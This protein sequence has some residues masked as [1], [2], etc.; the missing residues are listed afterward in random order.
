MHGILASVALFVLLVFQ[1]RQ[2]GADQGPVPPALTQRAWTEGTVRIIVELDTSNHTPEGRLSSAAAIVQRQDIATRQAYVRHG[3]RGIRHRIIHQYRTIPYLALEAG[4]DALRIIDA[5]KGIVTR[6]EEDALDAPTLAESGPLV[7]APTAQS[8][9]WDG[10]GMVIAT[11]DTGVD[12]DHPFL[13]GRVVDEAC[14]SS[15]GNCPNGLTVQTGIGAGVP[16]TYAAE[17]CKHGTHVAGI[18]AGA[19]VSF[20]GIAPGAE[21]LPIQVFSEFTGAFCAGTEDPCAAAYVSDQVAA[22]EHIYDLRDTYNFAAVNMSLG[23]SAKFTAPCDSDSRKLVIDNLRSV[24]IATVI[25]SGNSGYV[26][27]ISPPACISSAISVGSTEDGSF[28]TVADHVSSFSNSASFLSLLAPGQWIT[29]S[30]PGGDFETWDGT[31]MAT[32]HVAGAWA[33]MKQAS[34]SASVSSVLTALQ[35]MGKPVTDSR[36]GITKSRI[37]F[38]TL[39]LSDATYGVT[40]GTANA[41]ITVVR[42]GSTSGT[43]S[44]Q[45]A[46]SD[47]TGVVG[48]DYSATA[49]TLTLGPESQARRSTCRSSTTRSWTAAGRST[50]R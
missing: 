14:Y 48:S 38:T 13:S 3:L 17:A 24:G 33:V 16:C 1:P 30:V 35:N 11:L 34:P 25:A 31:S 20:S 32:P 49:G 28:G 44:V 50:S 36:N 41:T 29:S 46:A 4:P 45:Y 40:E 23:G 39:E 37:K 18:A 42:H 8:A 6:V 7:S 5:L 47:G 19:G 26:N 27:G 21:L 10:T 15:N 12:K 43:V 9:G 2:G 22:L